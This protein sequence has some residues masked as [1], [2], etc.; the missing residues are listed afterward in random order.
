VTPAVH[1]ALGDRHPPRADPI[2]A[3]TADVHRGRRGS[4]RDHGGTRRAEDQEREVERAHAGG[5]R[6]EER[7]EE[8]GRGDEDRGADD[9]AQQVLDVHVRHQPRQ[10]QHQGLLDDRDDDEVPDP[11]DDRA[12]LSG[13][14]ADRL[15]VNGDLSSRV[16]PRTPLRGR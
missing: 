14:A 5:E 3:E 11:E 16:G 1:P 10:K 6:G 4:D 2:D 13:R 8:T 9:G 15:R 12:P 7:P